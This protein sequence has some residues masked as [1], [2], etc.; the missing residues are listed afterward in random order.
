MAGHIGEKAAIDLGILAQMTGG[1]ATL[2]FTKAYSMQGYKRISILCAMAGSATGAGA[3]SSTWKLCAGVATEHPSSFTTIAGSSLIVGNTSNLTFEG[4][5]EIRIYAHNSVATGVAFVV[6]GVTFTF[7]TNATVADKQIGASV[8]SAV[9]KG[10]AT[11]LGLFCPWLETCLGTTG[12][13]GTDIYIRAKD[14]GAGSERS[15]V[16]ITVVTNTTG[17]GLETR[18]KKDFGLIEFTPSDIINVSSSYTHFCVR[19]QTT[20][21]VANQSAA[22]VIREGGHSSTYGHRTHM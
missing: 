15:G 21:T 1:V 11:A 5:N 6:D 20:A 7:Q 22:F 4:V 9:T 10:I 18:V 8:S 2:S 12:T 3:Y 16:S 13:T 14:L 17:T 19:M